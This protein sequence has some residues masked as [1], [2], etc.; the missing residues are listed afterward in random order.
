M[1]AMQCLNIDSP[2]GQGLWEGVRLSD[3]LREMGRIDCVRRIN[4]HGYHNHDATQ[5]FRSSLSYTDVFEPAPGYPP[6]IV[7]Y[8][9]NGRPLLLERGGPVRMVVPN[10]HGFKSVKWLTHIK[11]TN[12]YRVSDTYAVIDKIGN[13]PESH[14]KTYAS[15][16]GADVTE[17]GREA[18]HLVGFEHDV[19]SVEMHT[20]GL[21]DGG[22]DAAFWNGMAERYGDSGMSPG[23]K[24]LMLP[25]LRADFQIIE[26]WDPS[27][28]E[29]DR[30]DSMTCSS[31]ERR[32]ESNALLNKMPPFGLPIVAIGAMDDRRYTPEQLS[33]WELHTTGAF[34]EE[35][36]SG[37]HHYFQHGDPEEVLRIVTDNLEAVVVLEEE[38]AS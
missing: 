36:V 18:R 30:P 38:R 12:D 31:T 25:L 1:K 6:V 8:K 37:G 22:G 16:E 11:L 28:G 2:L 13:D 9:L 26:T 7:C 17:P 15:V 20:L 29:A 3:V 34:R 35:W 10:A 32:D 23:I 24:K 27:T 21:A 5:V 4:F 14:L 19:H 33:A